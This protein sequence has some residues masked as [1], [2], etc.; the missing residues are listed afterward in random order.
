MQ[1]VLLAGELGERYGTK[2]EYYDLHTP[3]DAIKLLCINYPAFKQE[4]VEAHHNGI[5]YKVI[6]G[7][8]AMGYDELLLPFGSKPLLVVPVISGSG[9][10]ATTQILIGVGLVAASFLLPG[11]GLFGTSSIFGNLLAFGSAVP[12]IGATGV[13]IA[14]G[15]FATALGT[16]LSAIGAGLILSGTASLISPQPELPRLGAARGQGTNVRG[17]GPDG[18]TRG[19]SDTQSYAFTGPANTVGTGTTLPVIYGQVITGSHLV[20]ANLDV[21]DDSDPLQ[22][23]TQT[24]SLKTLKINGEELTRKLDSLGGLDS[25]RAS[26]DQLIVRSNE[27][28]NRSDKRHLLEKV[29]GPGQ[30]QKLEEG[31]AYT[32]ESGDTNRRH[33]NYKKKKRDE[34]DIIFRYKKGLFDYV[35]EEGTTKI[36]G[37][38]T[39][40]VTVTITRGDSDVDVAQARATL[41]GLV[42][43]RKTFMYA[44]RFEMPSIDQRN[45]EGMDITIEIID[46][47]VH[48][49]ARFE[50][51]AYGY[52]LIPDDVI[53]S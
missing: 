8:A 39:Y 19:A 11:A 2:H 22:L 48:D 26:V 42:T 30:P 28:N 33:L 4:L 21:V 17:Q 24:P 50:L 49:D 46:L 41:Q 53:P 40:E 44:H 18:V 37:F 5:G 34:L 16:G 20:A 9:G 29:F 6:Q 13:G 7:G 35:G 52:N 23:A 32:T 27:S 47:A 15:A 3:A 51:H 38:I 43:D 36:D 14:G 31:A 10:G 1:L 25:V 45:G 12:A